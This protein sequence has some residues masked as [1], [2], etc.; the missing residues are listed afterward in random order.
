MSRINVEIR[1]KSGC[2][3]GKQRSKL[4]CF[5]RLKKKKTSQ[6]QR[7]N[8]QHA[9]TSSFTHRQRQQQRQHSHSAISCSNIRSDERQS[10]SC[11]KT[12]CIKKIRHRTHRFSG[13]AVLFHVRG[14]D[15]VEKKK[16]RPHTRSNRCHG[17]RLF[18]T[19]LATATTAFVLSTT[20]SLARALV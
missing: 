8:A 4:N 14:I 12:M 13:I 10:E 16:Q 7:T 17:R 18:Q 2:V 6:S 5:H 19:N 1:A 11:F 3:F 15:C 9:H 20:A